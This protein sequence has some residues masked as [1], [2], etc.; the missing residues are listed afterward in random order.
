MGRHPTFARVLAGRLGSTPAD[1][2][3]I[4]AARCAKARP[5]LPPPML[6]RSNAWSDTV[7]FFLLEVVRAPMIRVRLPYRPWP[8]GGARLLELTGEQSTS[9]TRRAGALWAHRAAPGASR[10][11]HVY[12]GQ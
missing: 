4:S 6:M 3:P 9:G 10:P 12:S 5:P 7:G 8:D 2:A 1:L 11:C